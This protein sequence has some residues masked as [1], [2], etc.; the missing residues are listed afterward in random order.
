M[1]T[2]FLFS[3]LLTTPSNVL[4]LHLKQTF[5]P[6][7][8]IFFEGKG[9]GIESRLPFEIFSTLLV[10]NLCFLY[11]RIQSRLTKCRISSSIR[12]SSNWISWGSKPLIENRSFSCKNLS[13]KGSILSIYGYLMPKICRRNEL[14]LFFWLMK[15][16]IFWPFLPFWLES[17]EAKWVEI[18]FDWRNLVFSASFC[19]FGYF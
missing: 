15:S 4:P 7:I 10:T 19:H 17:A 2:N 5:Q 18:I 1:S 3:S 9:D 14:K 11:S 16:G 13:D 12:R 6:I 8:W